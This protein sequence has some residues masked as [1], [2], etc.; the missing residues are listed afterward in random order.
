MSIPTNEY[1]GYELRAY[2]QQ[3]FPL[4]RDPYA[5]GPGPVLVHRDN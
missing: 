1:R 3:E 4:H 5:K 2:S